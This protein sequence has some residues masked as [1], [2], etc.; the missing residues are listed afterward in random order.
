MQL[1]TALIV[2]VMILVCFGVTD[3][4]L[5]C[6][7]IQKRGMLFLLFVLLVLHAYPVRV[8]PELTVNLAAV[9]LLLSTGIF[10]ARQCGGFLLGLVLSVPAGGVVYFLERMV[11][12]TEPG[13]F[14]GL[15]SGAVSA[16]LALRP[17]GAFFTAA[18]APFI[19]QGFMAAEELL[20]FGTTHVEAGGGIFYDTMV[21]GMVF[22]FLLYCL[23]FIKFRKTSPARS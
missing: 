21:V 12:G 23:R 6:L 15:A 13:L 19:A 10:A 16:L 18:F 20:D 7:R 9:L 11:G 3:T 8:L 5:R 22:S 14:Y 2:A 4:P 1:A 17:W